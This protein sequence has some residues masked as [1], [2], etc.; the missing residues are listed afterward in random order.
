M[1]MVFV[2]AGEFPMGS[3]DGDSDEKPVHTVYLD[4]FWIDKYE[5]TNAQYKHCVAAAAC[6][7]WD[8]AVVSRWN[9]DRQPVLGVDWEDARAYC[10]WVGGRLPT[11]AEWEKAARGTDGR[12]YPWGNDWDAGKLNSTGTGP[13]RTTDLGSY[14][15][16]ASPYGAL[17]MAGNVW[18]WVADWYDEGY[19]GRSPARNPTGPDSGTSR[20]LRGGSWGKGS[21]FARCAYCSGL[22]P[23]GRSGSVGFRC[24][25]GS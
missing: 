23:N 7:P 19:Y 20:V 15:G 13:G 17:D 21:D 24:A 16:G 8:L 25:R 18:E 11:E 1:A 22:A 14:P 4:A 6:K 2:A 10:Q 12:T 9:G 3:N 5:V